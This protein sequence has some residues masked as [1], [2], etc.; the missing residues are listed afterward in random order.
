MICLLF[1]QSR[2][3]HAAVV[4]PSNNIVIVGGRDTDSMKTGEIIAN[5]KSETLQFWFGIP[6]KSWLYLWK[7]S[8]VENNLSWRM[9]ASAL[10]LPIGWMDLSQLGVV[11]V[12]TARWT[13]GRSQLMPNFHPPLDTTRKANTWTLYLTFLKQ[14]ITTLAPHSDPHL[15]ENRCRSKICPFGD[16]LFVK[17]GHVGCRRGQ[18]HWY[19]IFL[20]HSGVLWVDRAVD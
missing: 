9:V 10:A 13:G 6:Y 4:L 5:F 7:S 1:S 12:P 14:E 2:I 19:W 17:T 18:W 20:K 16:S 11:V 3:D 15:L 8:Q